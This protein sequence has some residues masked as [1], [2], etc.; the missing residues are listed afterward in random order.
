MK[1]THE[2]IKQ[3]I[4][5]EIEAVMQEIHGKSKSTNDSKE[6]KEEAKVDDALPEA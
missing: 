3:I 5:E 6:L 1:V 4:K 2:E